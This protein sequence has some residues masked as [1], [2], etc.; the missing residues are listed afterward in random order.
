MTNLLDLITPTNLEPEQVKFFDSRTYNPTFHYI[1]QDENITPNFS[2]KAKYPLWDAIRTQSMEEIVAAASNLF[3]VRIEEEILDQAI[4]ITKGDGK[5]FNGSAEETKAKFMSAFDSFDIDYQIQLVDGAG[6]NIRPDHKN[7]RLLISKHIHFEY[8]SMEGE[9]NHE[10]VHVIRYLN[11]RHNN[12]KRRDNFLSTEEGLAS[13]CQDHTNDDLSQVQHAM[14]YIGSAVGIGSSLRDIYDCFVAMG[15]SMD[16]AWKRASRHKFGF[17]DTE[18]PGDIL[19]PAIYFAN[20]QK[21]DTLT[22][23]ERLRLFVG[24]INQ[25]DLIEFPSYKGIWAGEK[26]QKHFKL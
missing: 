25:Q 3:G 23:N 19:K 17:V 4:E 24:K 12:I 21:I 20:S 2:I 9:V 22:S 16:L 15:M 13:W 18:K 14:E 10:L 1:W 8:F 6:F 26:I 5:R 11:G 7:H